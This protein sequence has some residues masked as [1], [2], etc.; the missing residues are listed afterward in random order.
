MSKFNLT[1]TGASLVF[2]STTLTCLQSVEISGSAPSTEIECSGATSVEYVTG[3]PRFSMTFN[4]A[5]ETDDVAL[6]NAIQ[7]NDAGA[8][9]FDP[10][11]VTAGDIDISSTNGTIT[12]FSSSYPVNG[13]A[14]Y[15]GTIVLD[16]MTIAANV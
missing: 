2:A 8:M 5:L 10:A 4:G 1:A 13:F 11:G 6:L 3:T 7:P 12:D 9:A 14:A 15:S 16:D